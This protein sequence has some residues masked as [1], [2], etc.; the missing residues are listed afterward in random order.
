MISFNDLHG[1]EGLQFV[2]VNEKKQPIVKNWQTSTD[3]HNLDMR[4]RWGV[5]IVCGAPSGNVECID[6]D[7]KYDLSG[8]L[9]ETYKRLVHEIDENL[10]A[11]LVVQRTKS[12]G[13][14]LIYRCSKIAGNTKLA[15]RPT[16]EI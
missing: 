16:T 8:K 14:H 3:R 11:K 4:G 13:Y 7:L 6:I 5:G 2:P 15:N 10:L 9:F 12:G 1:I